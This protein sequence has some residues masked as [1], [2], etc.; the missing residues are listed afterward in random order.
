MRGSARPDA[1]VPALGAALEGDEPALPLDVPCE[2]AGVELP[3]EPLVPLLDPEP[4]CG[5]AS[6][7]VYWL[8]PA[9]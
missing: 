3:D 9:L 5:P 2:G 1:V 8:S 6:G 7:S 4:L